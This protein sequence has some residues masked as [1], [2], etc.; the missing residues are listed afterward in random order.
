MNGVKTLKCLASLRELES[1]PY[2]S[3]MEHLNRV[4]A[5]GNLQI[6][7]TY[8]PIWEYPWVW[9]QLERLKGRGLQLLDI[10]SERSPFP[11]FLATHGFNVTV[12]DVRADY[13]HVWRRA[14]RLLGIT[15]HKLVLDAQY[16]DI[17]TA[18]VDIYLSISVIE[19]MP[20][21]AKA[22]SEAARVLRP[23]G[24]LVMTFDICEQDMEMTFPEWNGRALTMYEFDSLF[25]DSPWF[26]PGL[27]GI[28]WNIEDI[29]DYLAWNRKTAPWHNY[30]TGAAIVRRS[31]EPW[32]EP[33]WMDDIRV[34]RGRLFTFSSLARW[35]IRCGLR[36]IGRKA[37]RFIKSAT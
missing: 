8:S 10:G 37:P 1:P 5:L 30:V 33:G 3:F 17:P 13:W 19:H 14:N 27:A 26:E 16:I 35:H 34:L 32:T 12:S 23:N 6:Y 36:A 28:P 2:K 22:I 7:T 31:E 24:L 18:S 11:W 29:S 9:F 4:A 21:K 25:R 15:V 20:N